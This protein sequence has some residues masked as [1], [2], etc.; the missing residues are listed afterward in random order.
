MNFFRGTRRVYSLGSVAVSLLLLGAA[1]AERLD[2]DKLLVFRD[3]KSAAAPVRNT[4]EWQNRRAEILAGMQKVM[5]PLPGAKKRV[6]LEVKVLKE[7][8]CGSYVR[9]EIVYT[10]EPGSQVPAFL[11]VP[12]DVLSGKT[13][14]PGVLAL[15]PTNNTEGNRP[16]VGIQGPE[17]KP[18]RNYGEELAQRGFVVIAPPYPHL[19]DY[20]PDLKGLGYES[21]TMKAIWDNIRALDVLAGTAGV[22]PTGFGTIGHSLGGHNSIYTAVFDDRI[23]AV[24]SSCGFD[25][26]LDYRSERPE[27][28]DRGQGWTQER[29][30]PA[31]AQ[32]KGRLAEIPFD[33]QELVAALAPRAFLAVSPIGDTNFKWK[34]VDKVLA[35]ALPVFELHLTPERLAVEHPDCAH[36]FPPDMRE[37]SY[38]WLERYLK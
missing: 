20:K 1:R 27:V 34:S 6:A 11:L 19:F 7:T 33:F 3:A 2:R 4:A 32:Y 17:S 31:L 18:N 10:A 25:S 9:R 22:L 36:D 26:F 38:Q 13:R 5:G 16:V 8:D 35:A 15:M 28:W 21:G 29:Y 37:R 23:K 30:M 12:K 24:V 14:G